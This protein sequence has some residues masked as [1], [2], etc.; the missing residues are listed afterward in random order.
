MTNKTPLRLTILHF[1]HRFLM[2]GATFILLL[3]YTKGTASKPKF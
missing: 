1:A 2:D 3:L